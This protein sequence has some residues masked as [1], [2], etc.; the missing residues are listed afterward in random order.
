L[1]QLSPSRVGGSAGSRR[2]RATWRALLGVGFTL[3]LVVGFTLLFGG[4]VGW[5]ALLVPFGAAYAVFELFTVREAIDDAPQL[6]W[7]GVC[8]G[9]GYP[10]LRSG[11]ELVQ[12]VPL[13]RDRVVLPS[14]ER[15]VRCSE[16]GASW[17]IVR[18]REAG[19]EPAAET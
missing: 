19:D 8:P 9:C 2:R 4:F 13:A 1:Q 11:K 18:S 6:L 3:A 5:F 17:D 14:H 7:R 10:L 12:R 15:M 16:C